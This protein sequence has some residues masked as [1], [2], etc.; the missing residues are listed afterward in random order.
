MTR[1]PCVYVIRDG[2]GEVIYVGQST[3]VSARIQQHRRTQPWANAIASVETYPMADQYE[4]E[5]AERQFIADLEPR[6]NVTTYTANVGSTQQSLPTETAG[7]LRALFNAARDAGKYS[8]ADDL[9]SAYIKLL[10]ANGWTLAAVGEPLGWTRE[11][12]RLRE[13]RAKFMLGT[14]PVPLP[15][16]ER[17]IHT[18]PKVRQLRV[19]PEV[20]EELRSLTERASLCR[21]TKDPEH[22]NRRASI[23]LTATLAALKEQ[24]VTVA[25]LARCCGRSHLAIR[26]RLARHGYCEV[27][28]S[29]AQVPFGSRQR[30]EPVAS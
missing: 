20:A 17:V 18:P 11:A 15:P 19:R 27:S 1:E 26:L 6:Y 8:H 29:Q 25:E 7:H 3:Q 24:G 22:P 12:V 4:A 2:E 5:R 14:P 13:S 9:F 30:E 23:E 28:P 10:R 21:A 16:R